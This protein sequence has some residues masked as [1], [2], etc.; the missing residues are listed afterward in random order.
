MPSFSVCL[1]LRLR[2]DEITHQ[3]LL[4][5]RG[6][7]IAVTFGVKCAIG[8]RERDNRIVNLREAENLVYLLLQERFQPSL[9]IPYL[10][11][12]ILCKR[13]SVG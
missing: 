13:Y 10:R 3:G 6:R 11:R 8:I 12:V 9:R 1:F 5:A 4:T 2:E 7:M